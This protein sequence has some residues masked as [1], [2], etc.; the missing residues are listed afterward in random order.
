MTKYTTKYITQ[1]DTNFSFETME[2]F[3]N[4][5][6]KI[7]KDYSGYKNAEISFDAQ[8][9]YDYEDSFGELD[10]VVHYESEVD[11]DEMEAEKR[12]EINNIIMKDVIPLFMKKYDIENTMG[13]LEFIKLLEKDI[14]KVSFE[15]FE[16]FEKKYFEDNPFEFEE[17]H[18]VYEDK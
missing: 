9:G 14:L 16:E 18:V 13:T 2:D 8:I 12:K 15:E 1:R 11:T 17:N 3:K 7:Y 4:W 6:E 5:A 10:I